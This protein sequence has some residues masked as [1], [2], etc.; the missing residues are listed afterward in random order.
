MTVDTHRFG[1]R[2]QRL[3]PAHE[4]LGD[5]QSTN[6][7]DV[8]P[9]NSGCELHRCIPQ[10]QSIRSIPAAVAEG[11]DR[12]LVSI[13]AAIHQLWRPCDD[14]DRERDHGECNMSVRTARFTIF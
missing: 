1:G 2:E 5:A 4:A 14:Y 7:V 10:P 8:S 13:M 9:E 11:S 6:G 3:S 12:Y